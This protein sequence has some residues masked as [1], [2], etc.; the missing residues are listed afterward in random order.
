MRVWLAVMVLLAGCAQQTEFADPSL[1]AAAGR[2][3]PLIIGFNTVPVSGPVAGRPCGVPGGRVETMGGPTFAY[4]GADSAE[5]TLCRMRVGGEAAEGWYGIWMTN[6]PGA[7]QARPLLARVMGGGTGTVVGFN[8]LMAP[9]MHFHDLM[10][11]EGLETIKLLGHTYRA[12]KI[13]HYREGFD[14]NTYRSVSTVWKDLDS[15][16]LLYGTYQ[17]I[18][19]VPVIDDPILPTKIVTP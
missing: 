11:N 13:S 14:N 15:G 1:Q 16:M 5:P 3:P 10:R 4:L 2:Y 17:H 7:D 19:G 18:S 8:N 12:L 6:W 9:G